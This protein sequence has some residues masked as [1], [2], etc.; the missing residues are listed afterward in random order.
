M[1]AREYLKFY[2]NLYGLP[3]KQIEMRSIELL[4]KFGLVL[5]IKKESGR[6]FQGDAAKI[7]TGAGY[8]SRPPCAPA[9]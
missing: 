1:N 7:G 3:D 2:G 8:A 6:V 4:E 5:R 9:G